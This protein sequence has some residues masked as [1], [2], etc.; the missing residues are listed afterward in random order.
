MLFGYQPSVLVLAHS[1][2][3]GSVLF[4]SSFHLPLGVKKTA[5]KLRM[6]MAYG[7]KTDVF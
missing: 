6:C 1:S 3:Q 7:E 5:Q 2:K 4:L